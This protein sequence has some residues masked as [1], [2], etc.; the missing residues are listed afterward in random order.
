MNDTFNI[1]RFWWLLKKTILERPLQFLGILGLTFFSA[2]LM[3]N[4]RIPTVKQDVLSTRS[5]LWVSFQADAFGLGLFLGGCLIGGVVFAYFSD[6]A[7][8]YGYLTL[9]VSNLEK[10]LCG[11]VIIIGFTLIYHGFFRIL[12]TIF[13]NSYHASLNAFFANNRDYHKFFNLAKV[14]SFSS[15]ELKFYYV[16]YGIITSLIAVGAFYFNKLALIK[17]VISGITVLIAALFINSQ[18]ASMVFGKEVRITALMGNVYVLGKNYDSIYLTESSAAILDFILYVML[19]I[20]L[21][22]IAFIRLREKEF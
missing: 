14:M 7:K 19:P 8:G 10:W 22:L 21:W 9:P 20:T 13:V 18:I 4:L 15:T 5:A 6:A 2:W 1:Q 17:T 3:Y 12:D 11:L 16:F